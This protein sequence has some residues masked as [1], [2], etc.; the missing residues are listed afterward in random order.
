MVYL[1]LGV[2]IQSPEAGAAAAAVHFTVRLIMLC[3]KWFN[4]LI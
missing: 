3:V 4:G 2:V 1:T